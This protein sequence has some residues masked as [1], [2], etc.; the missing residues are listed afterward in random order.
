MVQSQQRYQT[1][2]RRTDKIMN[3]PLMLREIIEALVFQSDEM[4]AYLNTRTGQISTSSD[5]EV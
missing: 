3:P 5:E 2:E 1:W 4:A